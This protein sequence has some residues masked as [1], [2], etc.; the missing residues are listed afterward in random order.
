MVKIRDNSWRVPANFAEIATYVMNNKDASTINERY[1]SAFHKFPEAFLGPG[2]NEM[3][4]K[5][6]ATQRCRR[7]LKKY[8]ELQG[9]RPP[10]VV[11]HRGPD[12]GKHIDLMLVEL[13]RHRQQQDK[14]VNAEVL[15]DLL[16][17]LL[18]VNG[19][20]DLLISTE[21]KLDVTKYGQPWAFRFC[22]RNKLP[23]QFR[24][25]KKKTAFIL[26]DFP[27]LFAHLRLQQ[28]DVSYCTPLRLSPFITESFET[29]DEKAAK[30]KRLSLLSWFADKVEMSSALHKD[31][32]QISPPP[33]QSHPD[34]IITSSCVVLNQL[35]QQEA[36][37]VTLNTIVSMNGASRQIPMPLFAQ[38]TADKLKDIGDVKRI[39]SIAKY[40]AIY[41]PHYERFNELHSAKGYASYHSCTVENS[42][43]T[44]NI[45]PVCSTIALKRLISYY[46]SDITLLTVPKVRQ[47][48]F[49]AVAASLLASKEYNRIH[50]TVPTC[51]AIREKTATWFKHNENYPIRGKTMINHFKDTFGLNY[52][53]P[54]SVRKH[55]AVFCS[56]LNTG[57]K[58]IIP[59]SSFLACHIS[60]IANA[61][62]LSITVLFTDNKTVIKARGGRVMTDIV[63]VIRFIDIFTVWGSVLTSK[64]TEN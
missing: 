29:T 11:H 27:K 22:A 40:N 52:E 51:N 39:V 55:Y 48:L 33:P 57:E 47:G 35:R 15:R 43:S 30:Q 4:N 32:A 50:S 19:K 36:T 44:P 41:H 18:Y 8:E 9:K 31:T 34:D 1:R 3:V 28:D 13:V 37:D 21:G 5:D 6:C 61:F 2:S 38:S 64:F 59:V 16:F 12:Y 63:L 10:S 25:I 62:K 23:K 56:E 20:L 24:S 14:I 49:H 42:C 53:T 7:I 58:V 45:P 26:I 54:V 46:D 60:A 17:V